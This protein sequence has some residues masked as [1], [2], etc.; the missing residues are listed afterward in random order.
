M[1]LGVSIIPCSAHSLSALSKG[2][3]IYSFTFPVLKRRPG[4]IVKSLLSYQ[5]MLLEELFE[6]VLEHLSYIGLQHILLAINLPLI[7]D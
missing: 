7:Y 2:K 4:L 5:V 1:C 6:R 3:I